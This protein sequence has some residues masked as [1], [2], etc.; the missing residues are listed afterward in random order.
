MVDIMF[1]FWTWEEVLNWYT[2]LPIYGQILVIICICAAL[3]LLF[4]GLY[5]LIKGVIYL[6]YYA[7]LGIAYLMYAMCFAFYKL[8]EALYY[9]IT[10]EPRPEE[11]KVKFKKLQIKKIKTKV[12]EHSVKAPP[13]IV[14]ITPEVIPLFCSEC[15]NKFTDSMKGLLTSKGAVFCPFCGKDFKS[16]LIEVSN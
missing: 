3:A 4:V 11:E 7:F 8:I 10:G 14:R 16:Q 2:A 15:G 13:K 12:E 6:V 1:G 5:Y 9:G